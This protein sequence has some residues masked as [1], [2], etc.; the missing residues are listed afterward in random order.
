MQ[1]MRNV[2]GIGLADDSQAYANDTSQ[3]GDDYACIEL[4]RR[5]YALGGQPA[6]YDKANRVG[7][8]NAGDDGRR[9]ESRGESDR[10]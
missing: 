10:G 1:G 7:G 5:G 8:E 4:A 6:E 2:D 3:C 9:N